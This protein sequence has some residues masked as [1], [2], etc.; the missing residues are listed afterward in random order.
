M[1]V[2]DSNRGPVAVQL[3]PNGLRPGDKVARYEILGVLGVG[4]MGVVYEARDPELSRRLALKL[5]RVGREGSTGRARL[6]REARALAQLNHPNVISIYDVGAYEGDVWVAIE[7]VEG[8]TLRE[9]LD[10]EERSVPEI[11]AVFAAAGR[12][13]EAAHQVGLVHRDV[14]PSNILLGD[15]GRVRMI[16]FGLARA[17]ALPDS[18]TVE[19]ELVDGHDWTDSRSA[20]G[21]PRTD[22]TT[23][24]ETAGGPATAGSDTAGARPTA[25]DTTGAPVTAADTASEAAI[26]DPS[27]LS[28]SGRSL[29]STASGI[30]P[31]LDVRLTREGHLAGT[32]AYMSP[33]QSRGGDVGAPSDQFSFAVALY[34]AL[35]DRRPFRGAELGE[36]RQQQVDGALR[37]QPVHAS[38]SA[39]LRGAISRALA[40]RPEDRFPSL[41]PLIAELEK[42]PRRRR[43]RIA[44]VAGGLALTAL[45]VTAGATLRS[46][47]PPCEGTGDQ[48]AAVW[49]PE[50]RQSIQQAF[51]RSQLS[52]ADAT[53]KKLATT[54]DDYAAGWEAMHVQT[55]RDTYV[56]ATQSEVTFDRRMSC[57]DRRRAE[58]VALTKQLGGDLSDSAVRL[59]SDAAARLG[60]VA[61]C[62]NVDL[63][64]VRFPPP[65]DPARRSRVDA[66]WSQLAEVEA[67]LALG[68]IPA[69][70]ARGEEILPGIRELDHPPLT[71]AVL[72]TVGHAL[73]DAAQYKRAE[74]VLDEGIKVAA[75]A[76][77]DTQVAQAW[78]RKLWAVHNQG[79][80]DEALV[81]ESGA[82]AAVARAGSPPQ[83]RGELESAMA[84]LLFTKGSYI[85]A[86]VK[87]ESAVAWYEKAGP[88][89]RRELGRSLTNLATAYTATGKSDEALDY[90]TRALE[91]ARDLRE[92]G[93]PD[94][95]DA[96][97]VVGYVHSLR[98]EFDRALELYRETYELRQTA[99]GKN[100]PLTAQA[101]QSVGSILGRLGRTDEARTYL[102]SALEIAEEIRGKDHP[103]LAYALENIAGTLSMEKNYDEALAYQERAV[104]VRR[105][106]LGANHPLVAASL[107]KLAGTHLERGDDDAALAAL[108]DALAI[109]TKAP[110][111]ASERANL[112]LLSAQILWKRPAERKRA[113]RLAMSAIELFEAVPNPAGAAQAKAWLA[114]R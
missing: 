93:H 14:K 84:T 101:A 83:L 108:D 72:S 103:D 68:D 11:L 85:E 41:S 27:S 92:A 49:N 16:D 33:E 5:L 99:L 61:T 51:S 58:L 26:D 55:C 106:G 107:Q 24:A 1:E 42:D 57:L 48:L 20:P 110:L 100:N 98:G 54:I 67:L 109:D 44:A 73:G 89:R 69:A 114:T 80:T 88:S 62:A 38:V 39:S 25:G 104:A 6:L 35:Y 87:F 70:Q 96:L 65:K 50:V 56:E 9:W 105:K 21:L 81:L 4:G 10:A 90:A 45:A 102:L 52:Y 15:D 18:V 78:V 79:R 19:S 8:M 30:T 36:L 2:G 17:H 113:R 29:D 23:G 43:R 22:P 40:P 59:A 74:E 111:P 86:A 46:S 112:H 77:D 32:P 75:V 66:G 94:I 47:T 60:D 3:A 53:F 12:G 63:V 64:N 97:Y 71:A 31:P 7:F 34:E 82:D 28:A 76:A 37:K 91:I 13:L 95:G